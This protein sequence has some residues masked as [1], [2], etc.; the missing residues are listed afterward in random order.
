MWKN[1][2]VNGS[3][4]QL[5]PIDQIFFLSLAYCSENI[6][7]MRLRYYSRLFQLGLS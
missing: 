4:T 2:Y 3:T 7:L 5:T 6:F 1:A